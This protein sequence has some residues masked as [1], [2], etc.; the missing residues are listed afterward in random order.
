MEQ[1]RYTIEDLV[2][3]TGYT[4]RS[5]RYYISEGLL[6]PPAGRGRGGFY[7][8][9]HLER[10]QQIKALQDRGLRLVDIQKL[11]SGKDC[12]SEPA[13]SREAWVRVSLCPGVELHVN[14]DVEVRERKRV[15][16]LVKIGKSLFQGED[17]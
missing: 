4:R 12:A 8:D 9:S 16:A 11:P 2:Y 5:I 3:L 10:L 1:R 14:R 13:V 6:D 15:D 7:Y 17:A